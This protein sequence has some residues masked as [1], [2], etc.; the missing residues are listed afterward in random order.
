MTTLPRYFCPLVVR[1][2]WLLAVFLI[3]TPVSAQFQSSQKLS[4]LVRESKLR[5]APNHWS[6]A[7]ADL[8][9]GD[10]VT[11]T[12]PGEIW[13]EVASETGVK[14][15]VHASAVSAR[16]VVLKAGAQPEGA[17]VDSANVVLAG[18]GFNE[19]VEE[20]YRSETKDLNYAAVDSWEKSLITADALDSF[21][22][23]GGLIQ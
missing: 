16:R 7:R 15:F 3:A 12:A 10:T 4:V 5:A 1:A 18:K 6:E 8:K 21:M 17:E 14:G 22:K 20:M 19:D 2:S 11:V 23:T 13:I 9:Y